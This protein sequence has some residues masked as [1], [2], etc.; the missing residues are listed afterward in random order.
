MYERL[1]TFCYNCELIGHGSNSCTRSSSF[2]ASEISLPS[3]EERLPVER[4]IQVSH[5]ANQ[6]RDTSDPIFVP[7]SED[8]LETDFGPRLL[9]SRWRGRARGRGGG[10]VHAT[11]VTP[12]TT[13]GSDTEFTESRGTASHSLR[14]RSRFVGRGRSSTI[15]APHAPPSSDAVTTPLIH[16]PIAN[17]AVNQSNEIITAHIE[18]NPSNLVQPLSDSPNPQASLLNDSSTQIIPFSGSRDSPS[19]NLPSQIT[20]SHNP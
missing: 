17:L 11:H 5:D 1:P 19:P 18:N 2:G 15:H 14:G 3:H 20:P 10:A 13:A 6:R 12:R 8:K 7:C 9:V 4:A 16:S